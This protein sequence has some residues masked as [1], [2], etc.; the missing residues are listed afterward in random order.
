MYASRSGLRG[1]ICYNKPCESA[2]L[3]W[4]C[5]APVGKL[6]SLVF[7]RS[8]T[9]IGGIHQQPR[10]GAHTGLN[11]SAFTEVA[12]SHHLPISLRYRARV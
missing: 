2:K 8:V 7:W 11:L 4:F 10:R 12:R 9:A 3:C 5:T 1:R 6:L